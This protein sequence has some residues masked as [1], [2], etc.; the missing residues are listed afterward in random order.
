MR[1]KEEVILVD[2]NN[3][4]IGIED[5]LLAHKKG[6]LH[7]AFSILI[8]NSDREFLLQKRASKKYH[9]PNLWTNTCCS[10]PRIDESYEQSINRRLHEEMGLSCKLEKTFD[11]IYKSNLENNLIEHEHDTV[12]IGQTNKLPNINHNEASDYKYISAQDLKEQ[13]A[14]NPNDFTPWFKIILN[15]MDLSFFKKNNYYYA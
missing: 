1:I 2:R 14:L 12:F 8:Y 15:K 10:H 6:L 11:F 5:K 4:H 9:T 13:I 3:N 7:R